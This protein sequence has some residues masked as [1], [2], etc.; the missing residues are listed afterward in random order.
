L[1]NNLFKKKVNNTLGQSQEVAPKEGFR[2]RS[3]QNDIMLF[4]FIKKEF[5]VEFQHF[6]I[7]TLSQKT[8]KFSLRN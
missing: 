2:I 6:G 5:I 3:H 8:L 4:R 7:L 1:S